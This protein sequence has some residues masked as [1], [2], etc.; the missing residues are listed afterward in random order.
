MLC[1]LNKHGKTIITWNII[2]QFV[3]VG[4]NEKELYKIDNK[5]IHISRC[6][7]VTIT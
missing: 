2:S 3:R 1:L 7:Q 5:E 4:T 6:K